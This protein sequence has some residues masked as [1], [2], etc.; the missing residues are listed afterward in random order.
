MK[1]DLSIIIPSIRP[2]N[3][4]KIYESIELSCKKYSWELIIAS[5]YILPESLLTKPNVKFIHTY[6]TNTISFQKAVLLAEGDLIFNTSD[7]G[8]MLP[9]AIDAG[10]DLFY[11]KCG[12]KDGVNMI[13][14]EGVLDDVNLNV[15]EN[16]TSNQPIEYWDANHHQELRMAG[17]DPT[18]KLFIQFLMKR[19][20]YID[21]GGLDCQFEFNNHALHDMAFRLQADESKIYNSPQD[22]YIGSHTPGLEKDHAP[23]HFAQTGPDIIK[24]RNIYSIP[25]AAFNRIVIPYDNWQNQPDIWERRFQKLSIYPPIFNS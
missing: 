5:P 2:K 12:D 21:I 17:I 1:K 11:S 23:V 19:K 16:S 22:V 7:D 3:L 8:I 24:F 10:V 13:Y 6:S 25:L 14:K 18:W 4:N 20:H 9:D 15:L